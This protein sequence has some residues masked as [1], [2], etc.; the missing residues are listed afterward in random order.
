MHMVANFWPGATLEQ[1]KVELAQLEGKEQPQ[2]QLLRTVAEVEGGLMI[3]SLW[4]GHA[5]YESWAAA[6]L[7]PQIDLPGGMDG[8]PEQ[9][10]GPVVH[11]FSVLP[12]S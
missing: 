7:M 1:L 2:A 4:E 3:V 6:T 5:Q 8:R 9:R 11:H 10:Q 12:A